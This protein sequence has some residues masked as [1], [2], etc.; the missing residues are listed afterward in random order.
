MDSIAIAPVV[1]TG[2]R[3]YREPGASRLNAEYLQIM[4]NIIKILK[5]FP[6][7]AMQLQVGAQKQSIK[8]LGFLCLII[9]CTSAFNRQA[10]GS[11]NCQYIF[12]LDEKPT[13]WS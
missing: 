9:A 11:E 8:I 13:P 3:I 7:M 2:N 10:P 1:D 12:D 6:A 4:I 5:R